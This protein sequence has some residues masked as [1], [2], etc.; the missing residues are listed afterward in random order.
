[1]KTPAEF[2]HHDFAGDWRCCSPISSSNPTANF[3]TQFAGRGTPPNCFPNLAVLP[4]I[5]RYRLIEY[6]F[7]FHF[8]DAEDT[9]VR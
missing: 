4:Q 9:V 1:L 8:L 2:P 3:R 6:L 5:E 7:S